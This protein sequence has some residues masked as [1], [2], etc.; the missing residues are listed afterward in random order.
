MTTLHII[1][2]LNDGGAEAVLYRLVTHDPDTRHHVVSLSGPGKYGP[3][4][5]EAGIP[6]TCLHMR[7]SGPNPFAFGR[8]WRVIRRL[9]PDTVQCW[10]YHSDLAGGV[11]ARLAGCRNVY[12][13]IRASTL[14]SESR[15]RYKA[16]IVRLSARLSRI[17]PR[18]IVACGE[19]ARDVHVQQG[20]D[21][22]RMVVIPNGY[23]L[24]EFHP[25]S[26]M[27][28]S[29]RKSLGIA[30]KTPVLGLVARFDPLKDHDNLLQALALL[31]D[32][33]LAPAC[34]LVGTGMD[35]ANAMLVAQIAA[36]GLS[37]QV[38]LLG[39]RDDIPAVMNALDLHVLASSSEAFPNVLAEAMACGTPC[40]TTDVGDAALIVGET[41]WTVPPRD[42]EALADAIATALAEARGPQWQARQTAARARV[43]DNFSIEQMVARYREVWGKPPDI[44]EQD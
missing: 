16:L 39:Q 34:L 33:G 18:R 12:W 19:R 26:R 25:D 1:T 17:V 23:D 31:R 11:I 43:A 36:L 44:P 22:G 14:I 20:Y 38:Q 27:G 3:L 42:P 40:V 6:V 4:L 21:A 13:G 24:A 5:Q 32:R 30:P 8:L 28:A 41:G 35:E 37:D 9:R 10:M 7:R 2:G 15:S 29:L